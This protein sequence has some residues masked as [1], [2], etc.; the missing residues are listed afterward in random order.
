MAAIGN[1]E[2]RVIETARLRAL[3][4]RDMEVAGR[5][6]ADDYWLITPS[7]ATL[8]KAEYLGAIDSGELSYER[9]EPVS[10]IAVLVGDGDGSV[11]VVRY[12]CAIDVDSPGGPRYSAVCWHTDC[13]RRDP[14]AGW[15]AV[16]SQATAIRE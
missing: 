8:S 4:D 6:H 15:Q 3:V 9:F 7:G 14:A 12:K 2:L 1:D 16:W 13:Y 10:E 5:L 11:A